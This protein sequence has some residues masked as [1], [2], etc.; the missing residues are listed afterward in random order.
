MHP[1]TCK[2]RKSQTKIK[3]MVFMI[4][5][6]AIFFVIVALFFLAVSTAGIKSQF[7]DSSKAGAILLAIKL[8]DSPEMSCGEANCIDTDKLVAF[9]QH[10]AYKNFWLV[11]GLVVKKIYPFQ[12]SSV[13]CN[14]GNY[15]NCNTYTIKTPSNYSSQDSSYLSLCRIENKNN[16]LY[17]KCELGKI[18]VY[19]SRKIT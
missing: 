6:L 19:T 5:F 13:E 15:P 3:E 2:S 9:K 11:D 10:T 4:A 16:Y 7:Y 17:K 14:T 8:A 12:N 18:I 1:F